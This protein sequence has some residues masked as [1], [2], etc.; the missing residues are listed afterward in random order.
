MNQKR[1]IDEKLNEEFCKFRLL[2]ELSCL[3]F[4][5]ADSQD[6]LYHELQP[7]VM[8]MAPDNVIELLSVVDRYKGKIRREVN[9]LL[10]ELSINQRI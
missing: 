2:E 9:Q 8:D 5:S 3:K 6:K 1:I 7:I 4:G 10:R